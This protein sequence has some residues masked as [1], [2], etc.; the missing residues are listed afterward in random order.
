MLEPDE[1]FTIVSLSGGI[2]KKPGEIVSFCLHLGP[3][4]MRDRVIV[5]TSDHARLKLQLSYN[6][7]FQ[8]SADCKEEEKRQ[9]FSVRDFI[10]DTC[11]NIASRVRGRVASIPFEQFHTDSSDIIRE[12]VFGKKEGVTGRNL[13]FSQN[14]LKVTNVDIQSVAPVEQRTRDALQKSVQL[15]IEIATSSQEAL[16]N[17]E[18]LKEE[19]IASG[20]L[21]RQKLKGKVTS[22]HERKALVTLK[23]ST[24]SAR[25]MGQAQAEAQADSKAALIQAECG[26]AQA[27]QKA[28]AIKIRSDARL[29]HLKLKNQQDIEYKRKQN[30]LEIKKAKSEAE[31]ESEKFSKIVKSIGTETIKAIALAGPQMQAKLL[32]GLGLEGFLVTDGTS[33]INLFNTASGLVQS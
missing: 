13:L 21:E 25:A 18:A 20:K 12:A 5:E 24:A 8:I 29:E 2:P 22:E 16:A 6:W 26:V 14:L 3:D 4:F 1:E 33:P 32:S 11:K 19:Q 30:M 15:A 27:T 17:H 9:I 23:A 31:I 10:G 28:K 7:K